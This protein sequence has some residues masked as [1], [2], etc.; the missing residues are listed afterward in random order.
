MEEVAPVES[1]RMDRVAKANDRRERHAGRR[2]SMSKG[3]E[4][5]AFVANALEVSF[6]TVKFLLCAGQAL[7]VAPW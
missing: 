3:R 6:K 5:L 2:N 4:S 1:W 7:T